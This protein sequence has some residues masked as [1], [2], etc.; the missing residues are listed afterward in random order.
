MK[1][2]VSMV[3]H[4]LTGMSEECGDTGYVKEYDGRC[5]LALVDVLGHGRE[6]HEVAEMADHYFSTHYSQDLLAVITGLHA[7]LKGTRGAVAGVCRLDIESGVLEYSGMGN[8]SLMIFRGT[9]KHLLISD[10]ILGYRISTPKQRQ[11]QLYPGDI[12]ILSS[13]GVKEHYDPSETIGLTMGSAHD[14]AHRFVE[15][16]GKGTDDASCIA[17]RYGVL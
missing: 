12:L 13:D 1:I 9:H 3:K 14:I 17:L 2:D 11:E 8:I 15:T 4:P 10:G 6:A 7:S 16:M 5:F